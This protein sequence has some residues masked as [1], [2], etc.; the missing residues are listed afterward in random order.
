MISYIKLYLH[1]LNIDN[2]KGFKNSHYYYKTQFLLVVMR[3][4]LKKEN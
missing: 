4:K 2:E 3:E 1:K